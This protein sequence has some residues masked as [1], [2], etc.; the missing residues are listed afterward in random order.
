MDFKTY[1]VRDG[2]RR[3]TFDGVELGRASSQRPGAPRW[4]ELELYRTDSNKYVLAR[5]GRSIVLHVPGCPGIVGKLNR[6]IDENP[7]AEPDEDAWEFHECVG[8]TYSLATILIEQT[9]HWAVIADTAEDVIGN[10][11]RRDSGLKYLPRMSVSV[12]EQ[13]SR[14]DT[15][16]AEAFYVERV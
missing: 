10:L 8:D 2:Q 4:T 12:L 16:M 15:D 6:F 13:A 11:Y 1:S 14:L 3:V 5:T 9:R 7:G